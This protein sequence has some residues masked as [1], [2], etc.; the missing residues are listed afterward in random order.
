QQRLLLLRH[1]SKCKMGNACTTKFCAQ[2]KPLWQ[3]M[4]KCRD[5]DCSTRHCQSSRCVL[6]HY[7]ICK[8]QG[9]TATCEI[10]GPV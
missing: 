10:C 5:K 1:A 2:M 6:T 4:K 8:S 7:R 9:K 3:H